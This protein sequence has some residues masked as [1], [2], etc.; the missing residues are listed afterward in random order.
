VLEVEMPKPLG[1][2]PGII[3]LMRGEVEGS[4]NL[5][6][7]HIQQVVPTVDLGE[8]MTVVVPNPK[9]PSINLHPRATLVEMV[10][11]DDGVSEGWDLVDPM[12]QLVLVSLIHEHDGPDITDFHDRLVTELDRASDT[13]F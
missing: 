11:A 13:M 6:V 3:I 2:A 7:R 5:H 8:E 4:S 9:H 12:E 1:L 10:E